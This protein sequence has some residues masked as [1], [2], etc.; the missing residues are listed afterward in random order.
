M[1]WLV[2]GN[3]G[4]LWAWRELGRSLAVVRVGS[5]LGLR[6]APAEQVDVHGGAGL[7]WSVLT[8]CPHFEACP[9]WTVTFGHLV[10][11]SWRP[12]LLKVECFP[13]QGV[14]DPPR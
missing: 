5:V 1:R 11:G 7:G 10:G 6:V 12:V 8:V 14:E 9:E 13:P 4:Y 3:L 2:L